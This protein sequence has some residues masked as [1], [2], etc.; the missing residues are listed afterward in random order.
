MDGILSENFQVE[1]G[2][3]QGSVLS[4]A[5]FHLVMDP[6][7]KQLQASGVGLTINK[8][9]AGGFL[10]A[11]NVRTLATSEE[12]L[13]CLVALVRA[14]ADENLLKLNV[15]KCEIVLF[16]N[17]IGI[18]LPVSEVERSV[19]R[20]MSWSLVESNLASLTGRVILALCDN[21]DLL[22]LVKECKEL[23]EWFGSSFTYLILSS[24]REIKKEIL[25]LHKKKRADRCLVKA[26]MVA[27]VS[28]WISW[29]QLGPGMEDSERAA[30]AE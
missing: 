8:F 1:R 30:A 2:L 29:A 24:I 18:L 4:P 10:H 23:E 26:P 14:F 6:L 17:Q 25:D 21:A 22:C 3:K 20:K 19:I 5:L 28:R 12:S 11:D 27:E 16:S 9:N 7:L 15:S 13:Q